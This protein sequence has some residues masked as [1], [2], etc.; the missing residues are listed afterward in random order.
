LLVAQLSYLD[1]QSH[2]YVYSKKDRRITKADENFARE[3][4]QLFSS[5]GH[6]SVLSSRLNIL[7]SSI[8]LSLF[9]LSFPPKPIPVGLLQLNDDGTP[10]LDPATGNP[11]ETYT[12]D[13]IESLARAWTGFTRAAAR[14]NIEGGTGQSEL[15]PLQIVPAWRD[16]FPKH[17]LDKGYI[18]DR[19]QLCQDLPA[20]S[21]LRKGARY[22]LLGGT[23]SPELIKDP[24]EFADDTANFILRA[25]LDESSELYEA[26]H[27]GGKYELTVELAKDL[28]CH[29][30][31]C[32]V[33][34]VRVV[35][36]G[37]IYYEW[38]QP[39]CVQLAFFAG[40]KKIQLRDS[41]RSQGQFC[42][43]PALAHGRESCC[44][45]YIREEVQEATMEAGVTH[46]YDGE[47]MT[48]RT[49]QSRC[50]GIGKDVCTFRSVIVR[51]N[52]DDFRKG[53]HWTDQDCN[54][55]MKVNP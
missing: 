52:D 51:P 12:N 35:K 53:Y 13:E 15:D 24:S 14:G 40:G 19:Y 8:H 9:L 41:Y 39:P 2:A 23:S 34:T 6:N 49:A 46:M 31:E 5:K 50:A 54:I 17:D 28:S 47:R 27:N 25:E 32:L 55:L 33:D 36:V 16:A 30:I 3:I 22:R 48:Y 7:A 26:L 4:M 43:N 45:K 29:G 11:L 20:R 38:V 10:K 37:S 18:G 21:F 42:A 44:R 1:S